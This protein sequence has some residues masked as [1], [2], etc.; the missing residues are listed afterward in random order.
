MK[1]VKTMMSELTVEMLKT[2]R[3]DLFSAIH[4]AGIAE[5]MKKGSDDGSK[6]ER[7]RAVSILKKSQGFKDMQVLALEA[8]EKGLTFEQ[9]LI[10]FQDKQLSGLQKASVEPVGPDADESKTRENMSHF[11]RA[12][13]YKA[14]HG[15]TMTEALQA[16]AEKRKK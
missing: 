1:E 12:K 14:E 4:D 13:A 6:F 3:P 9:A 15:S 11:E 16:T 10:S 5:G 8:I 2:E 7:E